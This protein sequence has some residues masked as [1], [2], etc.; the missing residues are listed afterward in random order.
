MSDPVPPPTPDKAFE[1]YTYDNLP[2]SYYVSCARY[3]DI[4]NAKTH[5]ITYYTKEAKCVL[6]KV[7]SYFEVS[8]NNGLKVHLLK[9]IIRNFDDHGLDLKFP[10]NVASNFVPTYQKHL[11]MV[12]DVRNLY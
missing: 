3:V 2:K 9:D 12:N 4:V 6:M 11:E 8:F 5:K 7:N 1:T 10:S